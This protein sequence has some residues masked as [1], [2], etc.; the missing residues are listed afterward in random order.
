MFSHSKLVSLLLPPLEC[1]NIAVFSKEP[2]SKLVTSL[3]FLSRALKMKTI[4]EFASRTEQSPDQV[5]RYLK[6]AS[7][8]YKVYSILKRTHGRR[9][10]AQPAKELKQYQNIFLD[11]HSLPVHS[12]AYAYKKGVSIKENAQQHVENN[13][14]LKMD[15]E[16][17]FNSITPDILWNQW[18]DH[19]GWK[20]Q[21]IEKVLLEQTLFWST[22]KKLN[23]GKLVLSVGAPSSPALSN[24]CMYSFDREL[25][26]ICQTYGVSY[27]RYADDL[28]FSTQLK[29][30]L[31]KFPDYVENLLNKHFSKK[32]LINN[33]KTVFTSKAHN[34]HVTGITLANNGVISLGRKRKRY[35]KH[36]MHQFILGNI[37]DE[38]RMHLRGLLA[39]SNHIEPSFISTLRNKYG[40][41]VVQRVS[42]VINE[43]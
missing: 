28:T 10:I 8:K 13:Y 18:E 1:K 27:T 12:C 24:L 35:I 22:S 15:L 32:I 20:F 26:E 21:S 2:M 25:Q 14:L 11:T 3:G 23:R 29:G 43:K 19:F 17:F 16:N 38:E 7:K 9:I 33:R 6:S 31:I 34:R 30:R 41:D 37:D 39:F 36:L 40:N 42:E 4:L 5:M